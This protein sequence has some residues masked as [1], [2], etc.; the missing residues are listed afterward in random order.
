M[1]GSFQNKPRR[2]VPRRLWPVRQRQR[3]LRDSHR[4]PTARPHLAF[5]APSATVAIPHRHYR[6]TSMP[7]QPPMPAPASFPYN[8]IVLPS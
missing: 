1:S 5:T 8:P 6:S 3:L 4:R 2:L 7:D